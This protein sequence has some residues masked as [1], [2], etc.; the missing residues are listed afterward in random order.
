[1]PMEI[2]FMIVTGILF[3]YFTTKIKKIKN[4]PLAGFIINQF[5]WSINLQS[6]LFLPQQLLLQLQFL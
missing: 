5:E 6:Q 3:V 4:P 1:M 2:Y